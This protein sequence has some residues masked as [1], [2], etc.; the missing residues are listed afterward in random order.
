MG[1]GP[2]LLDAAFLVRRRKSAGFRR[3]VAQRAQELAPQGYRVSITG[4]WPPYS[5]MQD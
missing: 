4:P 5:F 1:N 3:T 2:L